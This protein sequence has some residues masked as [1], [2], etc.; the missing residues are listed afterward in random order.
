[1]CQHCFALPFSKTYIFQISVQV[2]L[3][4]VPEGYVV[5]P[6][7]PLIRVEGPLPVVQLVET[8]L[9]NLVNYAR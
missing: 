4:A 8:T 5:F 9:L 2:S 3:S 1:V 7:V 6:K